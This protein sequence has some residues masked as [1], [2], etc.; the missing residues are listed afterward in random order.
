VRDL[1]VA[2]RKALRL[3]VF[4]SEI[5]W[6]DSADKL[7]FSTGGTTNLDL[8]WSISMTRYL[9]PSRM[10][11]LEVDAYLRYQAGQWLSSPF[12]VVSTYWRPQLPSAA[13]RCQR[14]EW[15]LG[16]G[17]PSVDVECP[18]IPLRTVLPAMTPLHVNMFIQ[19]CVR[20][21]TLFTERTTIPTTEDCLLVRT[22][23]DQGSRQ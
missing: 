6:E 2:A 8:V 10:P 14:G 11:A 18:S 22:M 19:R 3:C 1:H 5:L 13:A 17:T 12:V 16:S 9:Q 23:T 15:A 20:F 4:V 7:A 21:N